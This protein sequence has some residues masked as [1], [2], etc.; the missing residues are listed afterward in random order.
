MHRI[1]D[2]G[3]RVAAIGLLL[4]VGGV[5]TAQEIVVTHGPMLGH[6]T[7]NSVRVWV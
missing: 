6:V 3:W 5:A 4:M 7:S 2:W 1:R